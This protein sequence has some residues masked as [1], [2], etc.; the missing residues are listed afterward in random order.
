MRTFEQQLV[1]VGY[2]PTFQPSHTTTHREIGATAASYRK[3]F[4]EKSFENALDGVIEPLIKVRKVI[5]TRA[6]DHYRARYEG[7][8]NNTIGNTQGEAKSRLKMFGDQP[9]K[10]I[11]MREEHYEQ[12]T[13]YTEQIETSQRPHQVVGRS[14]GQ[15]D[16]RP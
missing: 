8:A 4:D 3:V 6:G 9:S 5:V 12:R 1:S 2:Q 7:Q 13:R 16:H 14:A 10:T 15:T 11:L